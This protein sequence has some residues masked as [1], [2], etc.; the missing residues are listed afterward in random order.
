MTNK[1]LQA[2]ENDNYQGFIGSGDTG[3]Q[4]LTP[5]NFAKVSAQLS[6]RLK[7]G[8]QIKYLGKLNKQGY[9]V[10]LWK[11][12]CKDHG[13]DDLATLSMKAGKVSGFYVI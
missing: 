10:S 13:D 12:S 3:F 4:A 2:V 8:Y 9:V 5:D 7:G 1:L 11:V 6:P